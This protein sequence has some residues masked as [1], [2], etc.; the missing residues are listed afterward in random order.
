MKATLTE[1]EKL[2]SNIEK[3]KKE[4]PAI[5]QIDIAGDTFI[6]RPINRAEYKF[7]MKEASALKDE[8]R[9]EARITREEEVSKVATLYPEPEEL[10]KIIDGCA[11]IATALADNIM[12]YSGFAE[13]SVQKL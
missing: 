10:E 3:W 13:E 4:Y 11:G 6:F 2:Q 12:Y 8:E 7:F 9:Q 1:E 5:Y